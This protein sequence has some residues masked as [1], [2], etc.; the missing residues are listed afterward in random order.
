[1]NFLQNILT[2]TDTIPDRRATLEES[3][4]LIGVGWGSIFL[5]IGIIIIVITI[6]NKMFA[7]K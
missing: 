3:L 7:K 6:L 1:M 5:V 2:L 4:E